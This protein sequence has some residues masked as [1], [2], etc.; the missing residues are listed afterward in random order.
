VGSPQVAFGCSTPVIDAGRSGWS[1]VIDAGRGGWS[2]VIDAGRGGWSPVIDA[3]RGRLPATE[4]P[5]P[6]A[7]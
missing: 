1:P 2:P 3:G 4:P 7:S 6:D 5:D